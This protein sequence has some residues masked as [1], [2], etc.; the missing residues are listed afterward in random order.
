MVRIFICTTTLMRYF[1]FLFVAVA[2]VVVS[3]RLLFILRQRRR[4]R[5][6][7]CQ[8]VSHKRKVLL[9]IWQQQFP[10]LSRLC[11]PETRWAW[12]LRATH[13]ALF[14]DFL[15]VAVVVVDI[16]GVPVGLSGKFM[17]RRARAAAAAAFS[18]FIH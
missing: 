14:V 13:A 10:F 8:K 7:E 16:V 17:A 2:V 6:F 9:E 11:S 18:H 12:R 4:R 1:L 3:V 15:V 5:Q